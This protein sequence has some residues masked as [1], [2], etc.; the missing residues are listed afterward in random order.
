M[1]YNFKIKLLI[2]DIKV[3]IT[4]DIQKRLKDSTW[5][6]PVNINKCKHY[7]KCLR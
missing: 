4:G 7:S 1:I 3:E 5:K 6:E 2:N